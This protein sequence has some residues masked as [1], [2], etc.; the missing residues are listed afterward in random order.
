M[1]PPMVILELKP[2]QSSTGLK[3]LYPWAKMAVGDGF[4]RDNPAD[5]LRAQ[6][7]ACMHSK[8]HPP[9]RFTVEKIDGRGWWISRVV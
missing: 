3:W 1:T 4:W 7:A 9:A 5:A 6:Q 8:R 2:R